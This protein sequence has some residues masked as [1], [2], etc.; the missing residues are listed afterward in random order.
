MNHPWLGVVVLLAVSG[1]LAW[2]GFA[3]VKE[4]KK[5]YKDD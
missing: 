2:L 3:A 4:F 5:W 1:A